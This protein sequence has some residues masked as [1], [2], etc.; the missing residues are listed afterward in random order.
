MNELTFSLA[1][2]AVSLLAGIVGSLIGLGG[3]VII[4]PLLVL[5]FGV[6]IRYAMG[7]SLTSVI[8]TSSGAA[9]AY[10][11]DGTSNMR[12]GLFL[13]VA[14]TLGAVAGASLAAV[15]NPSTLAVVFGLALMATVVISLRPKPAEAA[16]PLASD[17]FAIRFRLVGDQPTP[18]GRVPYSVRHVVPGFAVMSVA[19]LLSG[20]LGIGSG[21]FK[22]LAMDQI[23]GI[24]FKVTTATSNFMIGVTAAASVGIY[25]KRGYLDPVLVAPVALGVLAGAFI[26]AR[27]LPVAP[28]KVLRLV[29]LIAVTAISLQMIFRG[30]GFKL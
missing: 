28:V 22:V 1:L 21:A 7:A 29:F 5:G 6:D 30:L 16:V 14:T 15:L 8:A 12:L 18:G 20:L 19:G 9:A 27:L 25:L 4:T 10:L 26:G 2:A 3:G 17:P 24:P 11:R 13:C 23:M